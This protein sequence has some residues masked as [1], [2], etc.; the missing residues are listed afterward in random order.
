MSALPAGKAS[1]A[2]S[3]SLCFTS[4]RI[5]LIRSRTSTKRNQ[6]KKKTKIYR[7]MHYVHC[8]PSSFL[9]NCMMQPL[10]NST[11][12]QWECDVSIEASCAASCLILRN[13]AAKK[14]ALRMSIPMSMPLHAF[15]RSHLRENNLKIAEQSRSSKQNDL[16]HFKPESV[17]FPPKQS[18]TILFISA[19]VLKD[20][21]K[22]HDLQYLTKQSLAFF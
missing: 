8:A 6:K 10:E 1:L 14:S 11:T 22:F 19:S 7:K 3:S 2:C 4:G 18:S 15:R 13:R 20:P 17:F 5:E 16:L 21:L 12:R 9:I